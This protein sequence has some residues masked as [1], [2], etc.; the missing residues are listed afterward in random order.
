MKSETIQSDNYLAKSWRE[1]HKCTFQLPVD[2][3]DI[4][5]A[6]SESA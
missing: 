5:F 3:D 2:D 4:R 6:L 1:Q